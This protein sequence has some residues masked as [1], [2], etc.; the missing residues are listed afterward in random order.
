MKI[1]DLQWHGKLNAF[2][3]PSQ[4]FSRAERIA[5]GP[6]SD[7]VRKAMELPQDYYGITIVHQ[8]EGLLNMKHIERIAREMD[9][10]RSG[11]LELAYTKPV[12]EEFQINGR[13]LLHRPTRARWAA[14]ESSESA[15]CYINEGSAGRMLE[16]GREYDI[17]DL[18]EMARRLLFNH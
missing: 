16:D 4:V 9:N 13:T 7:L 2:R 8:G 10:G 5:E 17:D 14:Y 6:V 18:N 11:R 12:V 3:L 1:I 15:D